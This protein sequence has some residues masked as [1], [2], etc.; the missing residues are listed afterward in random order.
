MMPG[1]TIYVLYKRPRDYPQHFVVRGQTVAP[2]QLLAQP[3]PVAC[4]YDTLNEACD[5]WNA[6]G[7]YWMPRQQGDEPHIVGCWI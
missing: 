5:E 2:G 7:L 6:T 4:L 3:Q 1:W